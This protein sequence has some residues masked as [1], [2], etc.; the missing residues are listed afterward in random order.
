MAYSNVDL[1]SLVVGGNTGAIPCFPEPGIPQTV[2]LVPKGTTIPA[3]SMTDPTTFATYVNAKFVNNTRSS[4]W[5][6]LTKLDKFEDKTKDT[7]NEDTGRYQFSI[8]NFPPLFNFR[9]MQNMGNYIELTKFQNWNGDIYI[10]DS[11]GLWWG[12]ADTTGAGGLQAYTLAQLFVMNH[13]AQTVSTAN[14]Y[15][16]SVQFADT[17]QFNTNF[18]VYQAN[19]NSD[20]ITMLQNAICSDATSTLGTPLSITP[21]TTAVITIKYGVD[22][23]DF[24]QDYVS[25]L[26]AGCFTAYNLTTATSATIASIATGSIVV[27]TQT[28][29]YVKVVLSVAPTAG[30]KVRISLG[31]PSA[32][33]AIIPNTNVVVELINGG[34]DG[35]NAAV[36]TF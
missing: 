29:W 31:T 26:T 28:W 12:T 36:H 19:Y 5:F 25:S 21:T 24:V 1:N 22:S 17:N 33:N 20:S 13:K 8:Y 23:R 9:Y 7:S 3:A 30:D 18:R 6:A 4:R 10:I 35:Q 11:N 16:F 15:M 2:V 14:Q 32:V 27:G 34:V